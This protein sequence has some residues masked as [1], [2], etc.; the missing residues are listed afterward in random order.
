MF[1]F[2]F[3]GSHVWMWELDYK[4][5]WEL[6][7]WCFWTVVLEKT[8]LRVPWTARKSNQS[9]L[10]EISPEFYWKDRCCCWS[11]NILA[12]WCKE[13]TPWKRPRCWER[14]ETGGEGE[15]RGWDSWM[16][17]LTWWT[18]VWASSGS[19]WWTGK[20]GVLQS[21]GWQRVR[22]DWAIE[23]SWTDELDCFS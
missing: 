8:L 13:V 1:F 2:F 20:P 6:K 15:N 14:L 7:N 4:E 5:S 10:K 3:S 19:W 11:S 16:A 17:S 22:H 21:M 12:I 18:W 9:I 23:L